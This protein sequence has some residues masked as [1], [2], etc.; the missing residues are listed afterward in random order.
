ML[1]DYAF[2]VHGM[3]QLLHTFILYVVAAT[4]YKNDAKN[5]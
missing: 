4:T 3:E 5:K 2:E 1:L